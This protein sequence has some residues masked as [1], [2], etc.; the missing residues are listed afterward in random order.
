MFLEH[1]DEEIYE[2]LVESILEFRSLSFEE[3]WKLF[4]SVDDYHNVFANATHE[5]NYYFLRIFTEFGVFKTIGDIFHNDGNLF[6][7][8]HGK[9]TTRTDAYASRT[10]YSG[11]IIIDE[12]IK[13]MQ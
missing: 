9:S 12:D 3:K 2:E 10:R 5:M 6:K 8:L 4:K 7:F 11:Y 13:K 1:V